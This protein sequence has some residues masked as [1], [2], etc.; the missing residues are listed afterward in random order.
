MRAHPK[1][2]HR[3]WLALAVTVAG[4]AGCTTM[5]RV[6]PAG[7]RSAELA[8]DELA[9][10]SDT[11]AFVNSA[12][13]SAAPIQPLVPGV[14][15]RVVRHEPG[16]LT[17]SDEPTSARYQWTP[18]RDYEPS[19]HDGGLA[20]TRVPLTR[21][22]SVSRYD[23]ARGALDGALIAGAVG[24]ASGTLT[25][26]ALLSE[27]RCACSPLSVVMFGLKLGAASG[28][29]GAGLGALV[30]GALGHEIRDGLDQ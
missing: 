8:I 13:D 26:I 15:Y 20:P 7:D 27:Y 11:C 24:F 29:V 18:P 6:G 17:L 21:I 2:K 9:A 5:N 14:P 22:L 25:G 30:G 10:H 28:V 3:G 1:L 16:W 4:L 23:H 19:A 12:V